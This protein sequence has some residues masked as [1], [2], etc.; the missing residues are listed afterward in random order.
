M[1]SCVGECESLR[2]ELDGALK[3]LRNVRD[4]LKAVEGEAWQAKLAESEGDA[5]LTQ[6]DIEVG[7]MKETI[8][9]LVAE[10]RERLAF[11]E[12]I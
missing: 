8:V 2:I 9:G 11:A 7:G 6:R 1:D 3:E 12:K 5:L 4:K 10:L